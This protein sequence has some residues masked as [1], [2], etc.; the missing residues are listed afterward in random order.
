MAKLVDAP[1]S[2]C[3]GFGRESSS[4]SLPIKKNARLEA[5]VPLAF[6]HEI[7]HETPVQ[8]TSVQENR[9]FTQ[10]GYPK[11]TAGTLL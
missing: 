8:D 7:L 9:D 3:G 1:H 2:K 6:L 4:L 10:P 11:Q 5:T